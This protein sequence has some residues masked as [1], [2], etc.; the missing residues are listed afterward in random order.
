MKKVVKIDCI[1]AYSAPLENFTF[2]Q[3]GLKFLSDEGYKKLKGQIL[4]E[5]FSDPVLVWE[6]DAKL[7]VVSGQRRVETLLKMKDDGYHV[8]AIPYSIVNASDLNQAKRKALAMA[9][10]FGTVSGEG[11]KDFISDLDLSLA[12]LDQDFKMPDLDMATLM[13]G[14]D[15]F[16]IGKEVDVVG[17]KRII[18]LTDDDAIPEK[19][20]AKTKLGEIYQLGSHRLMCGDS[21]NDKDVKKLMFREK[22]DITF[23]SPP[24]NLG[25]NAA[26]RGKNASGEKSAYRTKSDHKTSDEYLN[27]LKKVTSNAMD[28]SHIAFINIQCL[29]G[30]KLVVPEFWH[31][32]KDNLVD[33]LI[34]DKEHAQPAQAE[35]VLNSVFEFVFAFTNDDNRT[36]S[37]DTGLP[38]RGTIDNIF[39]LNPAGKKDPLAKDHRAVFP[40]QFAEFF[41]ESF[42]K[43]SVLDI[44]GGSGS[45]MIAAE[46]TGRKCFMM[47]IDPHYCDVIIKRWEEFTGQKAKLVKNEIITK[48]K[49]R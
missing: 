25:D 47:E 31:F 41:I 1:G 48:K 2:I 22:A 46:K 35:H 15:D 17:H 45:T 4:K 30:N 29:A 6:D 34:W 23:T 7:N 8:P 39:R 40:V 32:F 33:I 43:E 20:E 24:Y 44:F 5:G 18:G 42:S 28:S 37:I 26:L 21:T 36:R 49:K 13:I 14:E 27:F 19:V 9:S 38:F 16:S 3:E 12:D 10:Q 11:L